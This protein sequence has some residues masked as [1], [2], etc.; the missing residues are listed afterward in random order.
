MFHARSFRLAAMLSAAALG[1]SALLASGVAP[2]SAS[3]ASAL[4]P[5]A[6][7]T[8]T[9]HPKLAA[10]ISAKVT[11]ALN[12]RQGSV[13]FAVDAEAG[14]GLTCKLNQNAHFISAS[15]I[16]ATIISALLLQVGGP[17]NL[18]AKQQHLAWLM[19]TE[20]DNDAA[21]ELYNEVGIA[22]IQAFLNKAGMKHT[23][24][25]VAWGLSLLTA[26]DELTLLKTLTSKNNVLTAA[27]RKYVLYLMANV[28][29]AQ[30]WGVP[31]GAPSNVTVHVKNGWL[32]YPTDTDWHVNS[33][34]AFTGKHI[35]YLIVVLT[36]GDPN[37][38]YGID[39]I[40]AAARVVNFSLAALPA[41]TK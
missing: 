18:T 30:R 40:Q 22:G 9:K 24:P 5:N 25:N 10:H 17:S 36:S 12:G 7:C 34:G 26:N 15:A 16:K 3:A 6:I 38:S 13:G 20:S 27:S 37:E 28:V 33:I 1:A 29:A 21:S 19:I 2:Q 41:P 23:V 31:A 32:G 35:L 14:V 4:S 11:A 8:S 39:T